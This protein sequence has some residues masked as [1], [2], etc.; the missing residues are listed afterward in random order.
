MTVFPS[1]VDMIQINSI[2]FR[3]LIFISLGLNFCHQNQPKTKQEAK[4]VRSKRDEVHDTKRSR[5]LAF[6]ETLT[7]THVSC[8]VCEV[9]ECPGVFRRKRAKAFDN[10]N[11]E[12]T[13]W[14]GRRTVPESQL[15]QRN[16]TTTTTHRDLD[17]ALSKVL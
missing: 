13:R 9:Y 3:T 16:T 12:M 4:I 7:A 8:E 11:D 17:L 6:P 5:L 14:D 15:Q 2:V 10:L 1:P